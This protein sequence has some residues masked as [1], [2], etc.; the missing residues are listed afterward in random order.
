MPEDGLIIYNADNP[1]LAKL[2]HESNI[3]SASFGIDNEADYKVEN[4]S[5]DEDFTT[6]DV[7]NKFSKNISAH[8]LGQT[9]QY[10]L[11]LPGKINVYN[12]LTALATLRALGFQQDQ[13]QLDLLAY[14]GVKRR[15]EYVGTK[16]GITI[17]DDYAHHPTAVK[18]TLEA[19]KLK[20]FGEGLKMKDNGSARLWA[21]F[22]PH[23][24]SRTKA[25]LNEL[26]KSFDSADEVLISEIYPAREKA[27]SATIKSEEV[28]EAVR[29]SPHFRGGLP[30]LGVRVGVRGG[31]DKRTRLVKDKQEALNIIKSEGKPGDVVVVMAVGNFNR[32]AYEL[33]DLI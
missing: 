7:H 5:F 20:Y 19:A 14:K 29:N 9:E 4:I 32:L 13:I 30:A 24:F 26:S 11:Q 31:Y 18:E 8:L 12:A 23:T 2:V 6:V 25:T 33:K 17:I 10:K 21:V 28:V 27:G 3:S 16:N 1:S 15:F 22:E